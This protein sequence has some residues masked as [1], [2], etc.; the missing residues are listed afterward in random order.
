MS[1]K[2]L[3][4]I[5]WT[6]MLAVAGALFVEKYSVAAFISF[7]SVTIQ[8]SEISTYLRRIVTTQKTV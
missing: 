5:Y 1:E 2:S 4:L 7:L 8:L 6:L 3:N